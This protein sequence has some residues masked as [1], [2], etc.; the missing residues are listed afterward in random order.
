MQ[1][2]PNAAAQA[3]RGCFDGA[4]VLNGSPSKAGDDTPTS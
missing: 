1:R 2:R 3:A 4:V